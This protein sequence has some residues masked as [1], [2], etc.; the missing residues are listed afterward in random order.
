[1]PTD[2]RPISWATLHVAPV[3]TKGSRTIPPFR[4][5]ERDRIF[6]KVFREG[7]VVVFATMLIFRDDVPDIGYQR[8]LP[9]IP[10]EVEAIFDKPLP[11]T[12]YSLHPNLY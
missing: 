10:K 11:I 6:H 3:P 12:E 1:M 7:N 8:T 2:L 9:F 5:R 4:A